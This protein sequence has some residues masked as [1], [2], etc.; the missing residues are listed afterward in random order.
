MWRNDIKC[1][2]MSMFSFKNLAHK[3]LIFPSQMSLPSAGVQGPQSAYI[4]LYGYLQKIRDTENWWAGVIWPPD[5]P[6]R[7]RSLRSLRARGL[8]SREEESYWFN[9][10][11]PRINPAKIINQS[12]IGMHAETTKG[13]FTKVMWWTFDD[14]FFLKYSQSKA[15]HKKSRCVH[16]P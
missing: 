2:Y 15:S 7:Q 6:T 14:N 1:K 5:D 8:R 4:H 9:S 10:L 11:A 13:C 3:G 12:Y 16:I